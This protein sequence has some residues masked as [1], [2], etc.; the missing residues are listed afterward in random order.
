MNNDDAYAD[1]AQMAYEKQ[2]HDD[3]LRCE[4]C[5]RYNAYISGKLTPEGIVL[6]CR[7]CGHTITEP[8]C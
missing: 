6:T 7:D 2:L 8:C 3:D 5:H 4:R 1:Q